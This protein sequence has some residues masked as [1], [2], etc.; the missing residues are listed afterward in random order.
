MSRFGARSH[1]PNASE[2]RKT[3]DFIIADLGC[4]NAPNCLPSALNNRPRGG[5]SRHNKSHK[6]EKLTTGAVKVIM[7]N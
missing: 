1:M 7:V 6:E 3:D 2:L 4:I 5:R